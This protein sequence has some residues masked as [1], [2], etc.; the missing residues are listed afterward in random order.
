MYIRFAVVP[1]VL[2]LPRLSV[3]FLTRL[4]SQ[5]SLQTW[6]I[7]NHHHHHHD[8]KLGGLNVTWVC[9]IYDG[10]HDIVN[11]RARA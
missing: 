4:S 2:R 8:G 9:W 3:G 11:Y 5:I 6:C 1:F 7:P 10:H